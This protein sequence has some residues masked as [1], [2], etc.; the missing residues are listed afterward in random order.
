MKKFISLILIC[1]LVVLSAFAQSDYK[2]GYLIKNNNDTVNGFIFL[3]SSKENS[4]ECKFKPDVNSG[5]QYFSPFDI[6]S[7]RFMNYPA[8]ELRG[9]KKIQQ[10]SLHSKPII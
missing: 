8:A 10:W 1:N 6:K 2:A 7:Y 3:G 5:E 4:K 9:I